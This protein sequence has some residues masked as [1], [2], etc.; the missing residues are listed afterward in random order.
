MLDD[1]DNEQLIYNYQSY[2]HYTCVYM[3]L[4]GKPRLHKYNFHAAWVSQRRSCIHMYNECNFGI[5]IHSE[6]VSM[7]LKML[8]V[9]PSVFRML[10]KHFNETATCW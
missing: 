10:K 8:M 7:H 5:G 4:F 6:K 9:F 2:I 3:S 1:N